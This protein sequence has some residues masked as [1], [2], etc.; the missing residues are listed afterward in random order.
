MTP[1]STPLWNVWI[2]SGIPPHERLFFVE[3][4]GDDAGFLALNGAIAAGCEE[5]IIPSVKTTDDQL[6]TF[7]LNGL[8]KSKSSSIVLVAANETDGG[9]LHYAELMKS[10]YPEIDVRIS[11]LGHLQRGGA[12]TAH[13]RIIASRMGAA[14]IEAL[15]KGLRNIM[16]GIDN[17]EIVH[18]PFSKVIR[19]NRIIDHDLLDILHNISI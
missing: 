5:A 16:I 15:K 18:V 8:S 6:T 3:V 12:P 9:A 10:K 11:I 7:I 13:D 14:S 1:P 19:E 17:D 4:I 2:K